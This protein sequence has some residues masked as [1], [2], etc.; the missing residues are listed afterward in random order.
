[1][2]LSSNRVLFLTAR[3]LEILVG[4]V[5][6]I[7]ALMKA[8]DP[9]AFQ[10]QIAA[11]GIFPS[12]SMIAAWT[13]IIIEVALAAGLIVNLFPRVVPLLTM[14]MLV[15]FIGITW[16]GM[17]I[18]LGENCGC[19]GNLV[20]RG[21]EQVIIE[22]ALM[23]IGLLFSVV[24]L[25][26]HQETRRTLRIGV[27]MTAAVLA[28]AVTGLS[29]M[30]PVDDFVTQLRPGSHFTAWPVDGLYGKDLNKG[31]HVV[32]L[33]AAQSDRI[34]SDVEKMNMIA[35]HEGV[36]SAVG[37]IIDGTEHLTTLMFEYAAAFPLAAIEPR[38]ARPLYRAL[39]RVFIL[40][41]GVVTHTWS[42]LPTPGAVVQALKS[43]AQ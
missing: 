5:F 23:A 37:L 11:Y 3:L 17:S 42:D 6:L 13:F 35:Q 29:P 20:H 2:Q 7:A 33:F 15:F 27:V 4:L 10:Q 18:G 40:R 16:Y 28:A 19:F 39:P 43:A 8:L 9:I 21:P 14:A 22:D 36:K 30:L 32:F 34:G 1:M 12:L 25:W 31:T 38:F 41:D 24:V 26:S